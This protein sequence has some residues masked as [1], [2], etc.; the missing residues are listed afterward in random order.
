MVSNHKL[1]VLSFQ[2]SIAFLIVLGFLQIMSN[3]VY[4][5]FHFFNKFGPIMTL[6]TGLSQLTGLLHSRQYNIFK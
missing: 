5:L 3:F 2:V 4:F 1:F 6:L